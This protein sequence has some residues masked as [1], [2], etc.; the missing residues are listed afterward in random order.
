MKIENRDKL[1][2]LPSGSSCISCN[3]NA[4]V[5]LSSLRIKKCGQ[6]G[7]EYKWTLKKNQKPII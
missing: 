6:C 3:S 7:K 1:S 5:L 2:S 4:I